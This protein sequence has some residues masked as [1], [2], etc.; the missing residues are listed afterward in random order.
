[1]DMRELPRLSTKETEILG[2]LIGAREMYGLEI[3]RA[4][5]G[6]IKTGTLYVTLNRME[7]KGLISSREAECARVD[8]APR[9]RMYRVTAQGARAMSDLATFYMRLAPQRA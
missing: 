5:E 8:G 9:R 1:M 6:R 2:T 7:D 4:S 3:A